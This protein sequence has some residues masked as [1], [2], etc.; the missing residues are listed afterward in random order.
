ML[1]ILGTRLAMVLSQPEIQ[2]AIA[3]GNVLFLGTKQGLY[4]LNSEEWE[5]LSVAQSRS[6]DSLAVADN[7][8]YFSAQNHG[9]QW[10]RLFFVSDDLGE[11]WVDITPTDLEKRTFPLT[12]GSIK[13][14][15]VGETILALGAGVL[16]SEDVGSTWE[17]LGFDKHGLALS[18]FPAVA[19]DEST[20]FVT[21]TAG[22]VGRST[23]S[24]GTWHPFMRGITELHVLDLAQVNNVLYA[25][26][27]K[28]IAKS[29]D[30]GELW[31]SVGTELSPSPDK[32]FDALQLSNMTTVGDSLYVRAKQDGNTNYFF[33]LLSSTG[34]FL[35][36]KGIPA[37][38]G[39][40]SQRVVG[41]HSIFLTDI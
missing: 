24:G 7:R 8:I 13:L 18:T 6:I 9:N 30:G 5:K 39:F 16:R 29:A 2:D 20:I 23:D 40:K 41:E 27:N 28:G 14:V 19:L 10:S 15:A 34:R 3:I 25:T 4:R 35:P 22:G 32:A 31:T 26:T 38:V 36:V 21:G 11:S 1:A 12:A 17:Y 37:Y 33:H